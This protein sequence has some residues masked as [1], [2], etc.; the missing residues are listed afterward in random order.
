MN[1][2]V[3]RGSKYTD[4]Q[5]ISAAVIYAAKGTYSAVIR[6]MNIPKSTLS[7]WSKADWWDDVLV[8]VRTEKRNKHRAMYSKIIDEA[9]Q[10]TLDKLP[11]AN[12]AQAHL[13]A[14]QATDKVRLHDGMPTSITKNATGLDAMVKKFEAIADAYNERQARVVSVQEDSNG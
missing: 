11:D 3:A 14:C 8:E 12:A 5:R 9:Q 10:Q 2:L 4:E 1:K 13:I 6:E 7:N